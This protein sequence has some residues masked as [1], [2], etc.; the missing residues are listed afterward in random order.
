MGS[1]IRSGMRIACFVLIAVTCAL[2]LPSTSAAQAPYPQITASPSLYPAF[3]PAVPDYVVRC[4]A[5]TD[6]GLTV[7]APA[8]SEVNVDGQGSRSGTFTTSVRLSPGQ[9]F[10]IAVTGANG[11]SHRVRCLPDTFPRT[12]FQRSGQP[13]AQWYTIAPVG[14]TDFQPPPA[15]VGLGYV[16]LFD[17]SGVPVWWKDTDGSLTDFHPLSNGN[18]SV[19]RGA[20]G[21]ELRLDGSAVRAVAPVGASTDQH[22][23]LLLPNGNYMLTVLRL[24]P[25]YTSCG[26]TETDVL[27]DG[28]QEIT[29]QG[30]VVWTWWASEHIPASEIP[31]TGCGVRDQLGRPDPFHINSI[32]PDGDGFLMSFYR[33][34]AVYRVNKADGSITWKLGGT[35]RPESLTV[36]NDPLGPGDTLR[37]QH[38]ARVLSDG[39]VTV[40]D[41]GWRNAGPRAPRAVRFSIDTNARTA[42]LLEHRPEPGIV[43]GCCGSARRLP[44]GNWVMA[45]GNAG[46]ITEVTTTGDRVFRLTFDDGLF[47]YRSHPVPFGTYSR[48]SLQAGMDAQFPRGYPRPKSAGLGQ[49]MKVPLVPAYK[50]CTAPDR[51]HGPPLAFGSCSTPAGASG[52]LTVGTIDAN[53]A[54]SN[55]SGFVSY[56]AIMG[57]PATA[58]SEADVRLR[59]QLSDVRWKSDLS[60]YGGQLQLRGAIRIT[61]RFNGPLGNESATGFDTELPA[62]VQCSATSD[63]ST[64]GNCSLTTTLNAIAPGVIT[65]GKR[66]IWQIGQVRV[67]DGGASGYAGASGATLFETQGLFVP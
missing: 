22:E 58:A 3:D 18:L 47:A 26:N 30:S 36:L 57:D 16:S 64:G 48:T 32:E 59:A 28:A 12:T 17:G 54:A 40:H 15:G 45:W 31:A 6:V 8:G 52:F 51:T 11:Q 43:A 56:R 63:P 29:P 38:D 10:A 50:E 41:N 20:G 2:P 49:P 27:D 33:L 39:T 5:G 1:P 37:A 44:G 42:T 62:L 21:Q 53:G 35:T 24:L 7:T 61:D 60:D 55:S 9:G 14:R 25:T 67:Y 23:F 65:E 66:A 34:N 4:S 46:L 13:Q 19:L